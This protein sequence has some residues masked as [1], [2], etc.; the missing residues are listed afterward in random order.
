MAAGSSPFHI[1]GDPSDVQVQ[2]RQFDTIKNAEIFFPTEREFGFSMSEDLQDFIT[3]ILDKNPATRLGSQG[4][5]K[6][7]L[8]HPWLSVIDSDAIL[9][10]EV[11]APYKP[12]LS[13][14][15]LDATH[16][17]D[18]FIFAEEEYIATNLNIIEEEESKNP[19]LFA[20]F[21]STASTNVANILSLTQVSFN[22][23][24]SL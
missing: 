24:S 11:P 23:N 19:D 21:R 5:I 3:K 20:S 13:S 15:P 2:Q 16:F 7:L 8:A 22:V 10:K 9:K 18:D 12:H 4:D 17:E 1:P 14:N 6:E